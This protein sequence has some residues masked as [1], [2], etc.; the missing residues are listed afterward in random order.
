MATRSTISIVL[1][2]KEILSIYCHWDGYL[3]NNGKLLREHYNTYDKALALIEGG[4]MSSLGATLETTVYYG[5]DKGEKEANPRNVSC[6]AELQ[7]YKNVEEFNYLFDDGVW[8]YFTERDKTLT[9]L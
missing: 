8:F 9:V 1:T 3:E 7:R 6:I 2:D 4:S 5:R